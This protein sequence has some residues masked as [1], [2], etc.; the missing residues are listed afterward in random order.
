MPRTLIALAAAFALIGEAAPSVPA[1]AAEKT[2]APALATVDA[3]AR[4]EGNRRAVAVAIGER[5][6]QTEWPAQLLKVRVEGIGT[7][8]VAGLIISGVKFHGPLDSTRFANEAVALV[9]RTFAASSVEEVDVWTIVPIDAGEH[10]VVSGDK[11]QPTSRIV[12]GATV[13]RARRDDFAE[14]VAHGARGV[15]W[16]AR[17]KAGLTGR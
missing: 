6:F 3:N 7:H 5:L 2:T 1:R 9:D 13:L 15:Y 16:D 4:A 11:A 10:A 8:A 12:F 14:H 17:W